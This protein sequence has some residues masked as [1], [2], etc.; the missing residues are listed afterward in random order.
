MRDI[1]IWRWGWMLR[2]FGISN[3]ST[4]EIDSVFDPPSDLL[5]QNK[6]FSGN[7]QSRKKDVVFH[8]GT[9]LVNINLDLLIKVPEK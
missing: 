8:H 4:L 3:S 5:V 9:L 1:N 7:V 2:K 6:K